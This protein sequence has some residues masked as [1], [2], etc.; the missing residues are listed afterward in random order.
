[1]ACKTLHTF[2]LVFAL[3]FILL[4]PHAAR[5]IEAQAAPVAAGDQ[6]T[7]EIEALRKELKEK[8]DDTLAIRLGHL[9]LKTGDAN[10]ALQAFDEALRLNPRSFEARI[11]RG[12]ALG[13][14][15]DYAGAEEVLRD[16]LALNPHPER[17]HYELGR[18]FEKQ[19]DF[20][21]AIAEYKEGL[22]KFEEGKGG[23]H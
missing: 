18:L 23:S 11:G 12:S 8:P 20:T 1:M 7:Q 13:S 9:L 5:A 21:R 3:L 14:K 6:A 2:F 17:V 19:G 10:G 22:K 15:G 4:S 16:A